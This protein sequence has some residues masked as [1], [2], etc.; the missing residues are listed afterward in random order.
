MI[1]DTTTSEFGSSTEGASSKRK[2][3]VIVSVVIA[4]TVIISLTLAIVTIVCV[5]RRKKHRRLTFISVN[6]DTEA[7]YTPLIS[8][9][10]DTELVDI[11]K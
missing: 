8:S 3:V 9:N 10:E 11:D 2:T 7:F 6:S 1:Q 4:V 5:I